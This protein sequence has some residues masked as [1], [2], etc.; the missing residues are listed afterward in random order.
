MFAHTPS[1][2]SYSSADA[3]QASRD[4]LSAQDKVE[5]LQSEV[6]RLLMITEALW[7]LLKKERG[8]DDKVLADTIAE[9]DLRDGQR[10]GRVAKTPPKPCP[11]CG[12]NLV[13]RRPTCLYCGRP[14]PVETF[15][16]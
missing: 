7:L 4:A 9:I 15:A 16:R 14:V 1:G 10:D 3:S 12:R 8:Y 2:N 13:K 6:D 5:A 11:S